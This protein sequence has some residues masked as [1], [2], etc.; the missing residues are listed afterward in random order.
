MWNKIGFP[1]LIGVHFAAFAIQVTAITLTLSRPGGEGMG[2][3]IYLWYLL[4]IPVFAT[5]IALTR[6]G[7]FWPLASADL[8]YGLW[9]LQAAFREDA[10]VSGPAG[11]VVAS[12]FIASGVIAGLVTRQ[13][14]DRR[15][16]SRN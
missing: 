8:L 4:I 11:I 3:L 1:T 7:R 16:T 6:T 14:V 9:V 2:G 12:L 13:Y 10:F 15:R 5:L